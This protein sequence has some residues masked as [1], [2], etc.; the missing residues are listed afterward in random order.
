[1][2]VSPIDPREAACLV[3]L[4]HD[5]H[6]LHFAHHPDRYAAEPST[7]ALSAWLQDWL[8]SDTAEALVARSPKGVVM[9]YLIWELEHRPALPVRAAETRAMLQHIAVDAPFRRIGVGKALMAA[10]KARALERGANVIGT[11]YAP[12]NSASAALMQSH[13]L[14]PALTYAEWR[15]PLAQSTE[16]QASQGIAAR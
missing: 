5:L 11:T 14:L 8:A 16:P 12:F 10:M 2:E 6:A 3:P 4:L 15:A 7:E 13:G 1:M 9:G